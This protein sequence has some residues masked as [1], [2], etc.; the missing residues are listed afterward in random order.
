MSLEAAAGGSHG[1]FTKLHALGG[2]QNSAQVQHFF[3]CS[4]YHDNLQ[5]VIVVQMDMLAGDDNVVEVM[6]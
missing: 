3:G 5:A 4:F 2:A 1:Q 6:L